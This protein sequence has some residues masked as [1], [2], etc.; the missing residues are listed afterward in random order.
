MIRRPPR[1]T[2]FPYTTLFRSA[3]PVR[4]LGAVLEAAHVGSVVHAVLAR[5]VIQ[6]A[7]EWPD[8]AGGRALGAGE[9]YA[10]VHKEHIAPP[11]LARLL[12]PRAPRFLQVA[13]RLGSLRE[14]KARA[15][16][17]SALPPAPR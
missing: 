15:G 11:G 6:C 12:A 4:D 5:I 14:G 2:L 17:G 13:R 1:S 3:V 7:A 8:E 10:L 16:G 9:A